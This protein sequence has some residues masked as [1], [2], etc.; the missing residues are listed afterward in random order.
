MVI[1]K[2][3][4]CFIAI[5]KSSKNS[6]STQEILN[7]TENFPDLCQG[8]TSGTHVVSAGIKLA[9]EG[10]VIRSIAKGGFRWSLVI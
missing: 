8:C 10:K 7:M 9:E 4:E 6:L 2:N 5:L 3:K 1:A